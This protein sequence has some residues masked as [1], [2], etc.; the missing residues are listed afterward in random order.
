MSG[1]DG[2]VIPRPDDIVIRFS[3]DRDRLPANR[4]CSANATAN[5]YGLA[6]V[7]SRRPVA[8]TLGEELNDQPAPK[9]NA[10]IGFSNGLFSLSPL[11]NRQRRRGCRLRHNRDGPAN[12][13][14]FLS[15]HICIDG[16]VAID[17]VDGMLRGMEGSF[18]SRPQ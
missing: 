7:V 15:C 18:S 5:Q 2:A 10:A 6:L 12:A 13:T 11:S 14:G 1:P 4:E 9:R 17:Q 8:V 16:C 3:L